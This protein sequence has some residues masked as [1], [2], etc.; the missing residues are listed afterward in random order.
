MVTLLI[1][2]TVKW[3]NF[4]E[5]DR[6]VDSVPPGP[7]EPAALQ[8]F[9]VVAHAYGYWLGAPDENTPSVFRWAKAGRRQAS[10][11]F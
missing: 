9:V 7:P 8:R 5:I 2:S 3:G 4:L 1:A 11:C 6:P 10:P